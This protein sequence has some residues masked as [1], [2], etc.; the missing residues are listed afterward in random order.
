MT[1]E[2]SRLTVVYQSGLINE[3]GWCGLLY[4]GVYQAKVGFFIIIDDHCL[5]LYYI[6]AVVPREYN[7]IQ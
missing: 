6:K 1:S 5:A 2:M 4:V 3:L 7:S